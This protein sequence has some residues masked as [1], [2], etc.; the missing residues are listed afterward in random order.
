M[1]DRQ[2]TNVLL[3][4][5]AGVLLFGA[6]AVTGALQWGAGIVAALLLIY[7]VFAFLSYLIRETRKSLHEAKAQGRDAFLVTAFGVAVMAWL[8]VYGG[9]AAWLWFNGVS[10]PFG[11]ATHST[12]GMIWLAILVSGGVAVGISILYT[13][14]ADIIPTIRYILSLLIRSPLAPFFLTVYG[15]RKA[16]TA[17]DGVIS[18]T[19][20][21]FLGLFC[22]L[23]FWL[24]LVGIFAPLL[25]Y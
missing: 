5:I 14:R 7:A 6:S 24:I 21:A 20:T 9:Y 16:R 19:A 22:G 11:V 18:S 17:G 8:P 25:G 4:I 23:M 10:D 2:L 1:G 15:W 13:R 12:V 3:A